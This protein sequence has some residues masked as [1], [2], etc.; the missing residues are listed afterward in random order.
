MSSFPNIDTYLNHLPP[1]AA[2]H[3]E[4]ARNVLI[5]V[6]GVRPSHL[7]LRPTLKSASSQAAMWDI[8]LYIPDDI[9]IL[10]QNRIR[11]VLICFATTRFFATIFIFLSIISR[12]LYI[13]DCNG[14]WS[15]AA[16]VSCTLAH[17]TA[18]F[19]FLQRLWAVYAL[20]RLVKIVFFVL[21]LGAN[22]LMTTSIYGARFGHIPGTGYC[23]YLEVHP[24]VSA[25]GFMLASF[26]TAVFVAIS[27]K[28]SIS[29]G[30]GRIG[31][32][33]DTIVSGRALPRLSRAVLQGGQQYFLITICLSIPI[34][35]LIVIPVIPPT[36][37]AM[38][39]FPFTNL[40]ASMA[41]RIFRNLKLH[42]PPGFEDELPTI[43]RIN[44]S[45][46]SSA[47]HESHISP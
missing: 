15:R 23:T 29:H 22:G 2:E 26:D 33:W 8:F 31:I 21:W 6:L 36:Y 20:H 19:I 13:D 38:L 45:D 7:H 43:S 46:P 40:V 1:A 16:G 27:Y 32:N 11:P 47:V 12:T 14:A 35:I 4:V 10:R 28:I 3:F 9:G 34:A 39:S 30:G 41:C 25:A 42:P 37:Q 17:L 5:V 24:Y 44:P 18:S